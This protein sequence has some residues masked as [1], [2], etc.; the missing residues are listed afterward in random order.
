MNADISENLQDSS[1]EA[2]SDSPGAGKKQDLALDDYL[3]LRA[4][5]CSMTSAT[6]MA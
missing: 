1:E 5:K 6:R 2:G 3:E 4:P